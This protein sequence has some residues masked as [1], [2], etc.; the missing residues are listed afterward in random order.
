[1][2]VSPGGSKVPNVHFLRCLFCFLFPRL[3]VLPLIRLFFFC[4]HPRVIS[5]K[6]TKTMAL[7]S[8]CPNSVRQAGHASAVL[9]H[10]WMP[11]KHKTWP[12]TNSKV[13]VMLLFRVEDYLNTEP[14]T[15]NFLVMLSMLHCSSFFVSIL[16]LRRFSGPRVLLLGEP[17]DGRR[18]SQCMPDMPRW[19]FSKMAD[20]IAVAYRQHC[21][22]YYCYRRREREM[23]E[24]WW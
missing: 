16:R 13:I 15:A 4:G 9:D 24:G 17:T 22:M 3:G 12:S 10:V 19:E 5:T 20:T 1:M 7:M 6:T 14:S 18:K 8:S 11:G 23:S 2:Q 21:R